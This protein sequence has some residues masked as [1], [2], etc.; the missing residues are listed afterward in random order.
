MSRVCV[1]VCEKKGT[2]APALARQLPAEVRLRQTRTLAECAHELSVAPLSL[3]AL[4][5]T[6]KNATAI[7][8]LVSRMSAR[9]PHARAMVVCEG[10]LA[11]YEWLV[12]EAGAVYFADSTRAL[13]GLD[14]L[15]RNHLQR[16][17]A[18]RS[19]FAE[20]VWE[21]LPWAEAAT[22]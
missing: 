20:L 13:V 10:D 22:A 6:A 11:H 1:I 16:I 18:S 8:D 4:E 2:W 19:S 15:M 17:P 3:V 21:A 14:N 5:L 9:F 7:A 12:R